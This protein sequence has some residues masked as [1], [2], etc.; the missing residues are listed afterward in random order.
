ML[1]C[2]GMGICM[3]YQNHILGSQHSQSSYTLNMART[4]R[5]RTGVAE[6]DPPQAKEGIP[7]IPR[8]GRLT[9]GGSLKAQRMEGPSLEKLLETFKAEAPAL[10]AEHEVTLRGVQQGLSGDYRI[11]GVA[12][13][14]VMS[15]DLMVRFDADIDMVPALGL[16]KAWA[17]EPELLWVSTRVYKDMYP[18]RRALR[19]AKPRGPLFGPSCPPEVEAVSP[20]DQE[21]DP[22]RSQETR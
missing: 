8:R 6:V 17:C 13:I 10:Y 7:D 11:L 19:C 1:I 2:T 16:W 5:K 18:V 22:S 21:E 20:S 9:W 12:C 14:D 3:G 15:P 4:K